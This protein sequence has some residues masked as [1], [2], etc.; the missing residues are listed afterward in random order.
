MRC[1][2]CMVLELRAC[3]CAF[4]QGGDWLVAGVRGGG[5]IG[6][7]MCMYTCIAIYISVCI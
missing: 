4:V 2:E 1:D 3:I 6:V 7:S 5:V